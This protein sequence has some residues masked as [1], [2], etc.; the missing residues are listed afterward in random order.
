MKLLKNMKIITCE[1]EVLE[2]GYILIDGKKI[3]EVGNADK[4]PDY[5]CEEID[6]S[7]KAALPGFVD[8]HSHI[9]LCGNGGTAQRTD[10]NERSELVTPHLRAVDGVNPMD[11]Y[12]SE[13]LYSGVT[14]VVT[15]PGST[16]PVAG[17][18]TAMKT[19]GKR[20]D[21]MILK[22][23]A[24]MKFAFGEN[25]KMC[26][27]DEI[28]TRMKT[29]AL[30]REALYKAKEY[31][32]RPYDIKMEALKKVLSGEVIM[33]AHAHRA[34]DIFTALRIAKEFSLRISIDHCTEGHL[35]ADE[36]KGEHAFFC[37]GPIMGD[38]SKP[39]LLNKS[40]ATLTALEGKGIEYS[41]ICDHPEVV[42]SDL[43]LCAQIAVRHGVKRET[44]L[45]SITINPAKSVG[46][47]DR[48]GSLKAGKDADILIFDG[49]PTDF[50]SKIEA[51]Y[52]EGERV[53]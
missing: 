30:I 20:I 11:E 7:G 41:I 39:E 4:L 53:K 36:L 47:D 26:H 21:N 5:A 6:F 46:I 48:V 29:A 13:A 28:K 42:Q 8:A 43:L 10:L 15:G 25:T 37:I 33:K 16:N 3:K 38:R 2:N 31:T 27:G 34:D 17:M 18:F 50:N 1:G 12:F 19:C 23:N 32:G 44:A 51:I 14:T 9:G 49:E 24:A 40:L 22:E 52:F 35:I 45:N